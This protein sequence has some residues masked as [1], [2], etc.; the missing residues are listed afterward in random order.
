MDIHWIAQG[1]LLKQTYIGDELQLD[2][3]EMEPATIDGRDISYYKALAD[4][5]TSLDHQVSYDDVSKVAAISDIHGQYDLMLS[6]LKENK[7][8]NEH[9]N[10]AFGDGH[11][12]IT[13][14]IFDRGDKVIDIVWYLIRLEQQAKKAGGKVHT[15]I[16]NHE[17]MVLNADVRYINKKYRYTSAKFKKPY[18][19]FFGFDS[20][21]G[22]WIRSKP[23]Y[24]KV[25]GMAFV[26]GGISE[27]LFQYMS[28]DD[29]NKVY[30][31]K[32][33]SVEDA[34]EEPV[35]ELV[36]FLTN[37]NSPLWYRGYAFKDEY[38]KKRTDKL[39]KMLDAKRIIVG[40]TSM[41]EIVSIHNN[42][43]IFIDSSIKLG[44]KGEML[45][46]EGKKLYRADNWGKRTKLN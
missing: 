17:W 41:P 9:G 27:E 37:V 8:V 42:K 40:H 38:D 5:G 16:G 45:L 22:S 33:L 44:E 34:A 3:E 31:D 14:D 39:L 30:Y 19:E 12:V 43:I 1:K 46:V 29:L 25:N 26:H 24:I 4:N 23:I 7:I 28:I 20:F 18:N 32:V 6:L 36:D 13:G 21:L 2:S 35:D 15:L 11:L 10:W